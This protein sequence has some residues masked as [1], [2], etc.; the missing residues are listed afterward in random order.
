MS[1][2]TTNGCFGVV[3]WEL[4]EQTWHSRFA[5]VGHLFT[6]LGTIGLCYSVMRRCWRASKDQSVGKTSKDF[7]DLLSSCPEEGWFQ[8]MA[9]SEST[10]TIRSPFE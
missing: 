4:W 2:M 8:Q 1:V 3:L 6:G 9:R 10:D 5:T 7:V